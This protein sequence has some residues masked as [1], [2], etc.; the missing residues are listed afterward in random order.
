VISHASAGDLLRVAEARLDR[1]IVEL[2]VEEANRLLAAG[3]TAEDLPRLMQPF[4]ETLWQWR[5]D[6]MADVHARVRWIRLIEA[7][8]ALNEA[9][10]AQAE[11]LIARNAACMAYRG[12]EGLAVH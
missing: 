5:A 3:A 4:V 11:T 7:R 8:I 2:A 10:L 6:T 9:L 12:V 1:A